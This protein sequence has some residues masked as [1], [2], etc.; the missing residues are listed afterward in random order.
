ANL[1]TADAGDYDCVISNVAGAA[2]S[3]AATLTVNKAVANITLSGLTA[4]YDGAPKPITV[5]TT[6]GGLGIQV[7]YNG[8]TMP[9]TNAGSYAALAT[10]V[11]AN[12]LRSEER[13]V[14]KEGRS[15]WSPY[16]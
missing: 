2:T 15:R 7:T 10:I 9:P 14:G 11:D 1:T 5:G 16:H 13:R 8:S 12:Y 4:T 6:P 3:T